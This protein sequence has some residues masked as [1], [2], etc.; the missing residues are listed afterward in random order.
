MSQSIL[1]KVNPEKE[2]IS[3]VGANQEGKT[4]FVV[5]LVASLHEQGFNV[6]VLDPH[7]KFTKLGAQ[8]VKTTLADVRGIGLEIVQP[9]EISQQFFLNLADKIYNQIKHYVIFVIDELH[10]YLQ[11]Q[12][13]KETK[14]VQTLFENCNN[15]DIG[16]IAI[17]HSPSE[18]PNYVM[19]TSQVLFLFYTDVVSDKAYLKKWVGDVVDG[20][21]DNTIQ[22][23]QAICKIRHEEPIIFDA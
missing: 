15:R 6:I 5:K 9:Y 20:F 2:N 8:F 3:V 12:P 4:E 17:Y 14:I 11:K 7:K 21:F 13:T 1:H 22:K 23:Y 18:V 16:Y 10:N 19:R